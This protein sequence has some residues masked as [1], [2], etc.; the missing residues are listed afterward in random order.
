M[1]QSGFTLIELSIVLVI[2]GLIV[3]TITVGSSMIRQSHIMSAAADAQTYISAVN[4]FQQKY[5]ALPG[6]FASATSYWGTNPNCATGGAGTGTQTCNGN[7]D[8]HITYWVNPLNVMEGIYAWQHLANAGMI[9]GTYP[10]AS[11]NMPYGKF[12][13]GYNIPQSKL[14]NAGFSL[15]YVGV[16]PTDGAGTVNGFFVNWYAANYGHILV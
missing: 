14:T 2:I 15:F 12:Q 6:D 10:G 5:T 1:K 9:N 7:G 4:T 16:I 3:G 13:P 8:G 11:T